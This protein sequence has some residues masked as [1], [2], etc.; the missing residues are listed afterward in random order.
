MSTNNFVYPHPINVFIIKQL[1]ITVDDFCDIHGYSQS[2]VATWVS[3]ERK[4]ELLP[5]SFIYAMSL[6]ASKSMDQVYESLIDLQV[7]YDKYIEENKR[8]KMNLEDD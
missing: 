4:V 1:G 7:A 3:R 5:A 2:T 6:S 8:T